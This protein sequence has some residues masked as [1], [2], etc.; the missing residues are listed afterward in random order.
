MLNKFKS[1]FL[2]NNSLTHLQQSKLF[3]DDLEFLLGDFE[4]LVKFLMHPKNVEDFFILVNSE[5]NLSKWLY[6]SKLFIL[7]N[8]LLRN[9]VNE[10][11]INEIMA[12][13]LTNYIN[14]EDQ[15]DNMQINMNQIQH[16][17]ITYCQRL[18]SCLYAS[19]KKVVLAEY[20]QTT[21][22]AKLQPQQHQSLQ[23][24]SPVPKSNFTPNHFHAPLK[25]N[26]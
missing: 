1:L 2:V 17:L 10:A 21:E 8:A 9:E 11:F 15:S 12:V 4:W 26:P 20:L 19:V 13:R 14:T 7:C 25:R 24:H 23:K 5:Q 3:S 6:R 18:A 22:F 16:I